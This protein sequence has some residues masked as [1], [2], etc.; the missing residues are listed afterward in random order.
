[1]RQFNKTF[2]GAEPSG[3]NAC[4][5]ENGNP[6]YTEYAN[7][8]A[9]A[10]I[11]LI[12]IAI[13]EVRM[14]ELIYPICFN[15]R[16][17]VELR[18]KQFVFELSGIREN[19]N[20]NDFKDTKLHSIKNIWE[21]YKGKAIEVDRRFYNKLLDIEE[22]VLDIAEIDPTG[23]V[24]RYPYSTGNAKH[25][26]DVSLIN[27]VHLKSIFTELQKNLENIQFF[28]SALKE[29]YQT[30]TYT[31]VSS[32]N[33]IE[34][35]SKILP[36]A[37]EWRN[38]INKCLD[39]KERVVE[40]F[41]IS[42]NEFGRIKNIIE[43]HYSFSKNVGIEVS[44]KYSSLDDWLAVFNAFNF[45]REK[46][47]VNTEIVPSNS[48]GFDDVASAGVGITDSVK[49]CIERIDI[50]AFID[51][52]SVYEV[53]RYGKYCEYYDQILKSEINLSARHK[54]NSI[55]RK[56]YIHY[57]MAKSNFHKF[58]I[59]GLII[60]GQCSILEYLYETGLVSPEC[61]TNQIRL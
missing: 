13:D 2:R 17:A 58:A 22:I 35:I 61:F 57:V 39:I 15:M 24:F 31:T 52:F 12:N 27:L 33:D 19:V 36:N 3:F 16:H 23:Q 1:M 42:S 28:T 18:L 47:Y 43:K 6:S 25:L 40:I 45:N 49:Y 14:D 21:Y 10:A 34:Q 41:S 20:I 48:I 60:L 5:G 54:A 38:N 11:Y 37:L 55:E 46:S 9:E 29:E 7:G 8:F 56:N 59:K 50:E 53:G 51:I 44:L 4:V 30:G 32:R 26:I